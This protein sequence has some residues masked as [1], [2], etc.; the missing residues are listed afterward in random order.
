MSQGYTLMKQMV[1]L[2]VSRMIR[3]LFAPFYVI[4]IEYREKTMKTINWL[5]SIGKFLSISAQ[6]L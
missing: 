4:K 5:H 3:I 1:F 6:M 2:S